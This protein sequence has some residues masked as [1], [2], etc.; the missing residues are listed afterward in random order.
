MIGK[1]D[2]QPQLNI[3]KI[4]L[5]QIIDLNHELC[6]LSKKIDWEKVEEDFSQ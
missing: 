5:N 3:F 2:K 6:L 1:T 4:P